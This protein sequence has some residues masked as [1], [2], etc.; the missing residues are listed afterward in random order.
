MRAKTDKQSERYVQVGE[1][2]WKEERKEERGEMNEE[3]Q[4]DR[5]K[6]IKS[7]MESGQKERRGEELDRGMKSWIE[8]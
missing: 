4:G 3:R 2:T 1:K 8:R 5:V 7:N 6:E